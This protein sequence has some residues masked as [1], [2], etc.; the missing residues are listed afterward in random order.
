MVIET[1]N[2]AANW[3]AN[4]S[5][6]GVITLGAW[7]HLTYRFDVLNSS[8]IFFINGVPITSGFV[9]SVTN[10]IT[11]GRTFDIGAYT[12]GAGSFSMNAQLGY[13][14]VFNSLLDATQI[15]ADYTSSSASF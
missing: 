4:G 3:S 9:T 12:N 11:N 1:G 14:K 2:A 6:A 8:C 5:P 7:Q 13:L 15:L 10:T